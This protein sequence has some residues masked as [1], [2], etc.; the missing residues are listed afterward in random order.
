[1]SP[2]DAAHHSIIALVRHG[3]AVRLCVQVPHKEAVQLLVARQLRCIQPMTH[4]L[5]TST[6]TSTSTLSL[7]YICMVQFSFS[8]FSWGRVDQPTSPVPVLQGK[9]GR[10]STNRAS[11]YEH[12]KHLKLQPQQYGTPPR[13]HKERIVCG[14]HW[15][16]NHKEHTLPYFTSDGR[17]LTQLLIKSSTAPPAGS[18]REHGRVWRV[19]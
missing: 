15:T 2:P 13:V 7:S 17:W 12:S 14:E 10:L 5:H 3:P 4:H 9:R 6:S 16:S 18:H 1:M 19:P 8:F 11:L